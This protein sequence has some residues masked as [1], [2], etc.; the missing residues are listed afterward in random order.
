MK[1]ILLSFLHAY[2]KKTVSLGEL[3][4]LAGGDTCY[5]D[6][7]AVIIEFTKSGVLQP[8]K[9]HGTSLKNPC[10]IIPTVL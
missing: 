5:Q 10:C 2:S 4:K 6:F 8:V 1:D 9:N 3:E 7:A